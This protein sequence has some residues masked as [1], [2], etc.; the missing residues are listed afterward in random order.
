MHPVY[1]IGVPIMIAMRL[2][3]GLVGG[4]A[5]WPGA[6]IALGQLRLPG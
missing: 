6:A 4:S 1:R 5:V 3:M 2:T